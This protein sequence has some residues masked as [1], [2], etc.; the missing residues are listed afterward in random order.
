[1][2]L[3]MSGYRYNLKKNK[4]EKT[5]TLILETIPPKAQIFIDDELTNLTTPAH[6][7][8][9]F[10][11]RYKVTLKKDG[12]HP[13]NKNMYVQS[14][15]AT[16]AKEIPLIKKKPPQIL[17]QADMDWVEDIP[18]FN[19]VLLSKKENSKIILGLLY[20]NTK[21]FI[22]L[23]S[24]QIYKN[25]EQ[26]ND[27]KVLGWSSKK[28]N[29]LIAKKQN[30]STE[31][32]IFNTENFRLLSLGQSVKSPFKKII[33]DE[34]ENNTLYG[35]YN[36]TIYKINLVKNDFHALKLSKEPL[37]D[38]LISL[39][40]MYFIMKN[41]ND[42]FLVKKS[43]ILNDETLLRLPKLSDY[44]F[45]PH[46]KDMLLL[47]DNNSKKIFLFNKNIFNNKN[48]TEN[49]VVLEEYAD[50]VSLTPQY[51]K[52]ALY[53]KLEI[54]TYDVKKNSYNLVT[55]LSQDIKRVS[56]V[57]E[58]SYL[59][60]QTENTLTMIESDT[61]E[62][63]NK[64]ELVVM[65]EMRY[66]FADRKNIYVYGIINSQEGIYKLEIF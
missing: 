24:I 52:L 27:Y 13:W 15:Y 49:S 4:I 41:K 46:P 33:W 28:N 19:T 38:F 47:L 48:L 2:V 30:K 43:L 55:R 45:L 29:L 34:D 59:L 21:N 66:F 62:T 10:P 36:N 7:N 18:Y 20:L 50:R 3:Y 63:I 44:S 6:I 26:E 56:W 17:F 39:D 22:P 8:R 23:D 9:I 37:D 51:N 14:R 25:N 60:Y 57:P 1:M 16:F 5:G 65:D 42:S 31:Y 32:L 35:E 12:Y 53:N 40:T 54:A 58:T 11:G 64:Y 61:Q